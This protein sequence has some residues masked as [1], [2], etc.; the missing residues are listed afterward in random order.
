MNQIIGFAPIAKENAK[1]LILGSMPSD[2][3]LQKQQYYGHQ[4]NAFWPIM[5][6]LL[7]KNIDLDQIDYSQRKKLLIENNIAVWDVLQ[8]CHRSGSL[9]TAIKMNSIQ[10]NPF[11]QFFT[12]HRLISKICFNGA[13]AES[14][15]VKYVLP[16]VRDQFETMKYVRLPSTSPAHAAMTLLQKTQYW[17]KELKSDAAKYN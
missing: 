7:N 4:R 6:S 9:D 10:V 5:L 17:K 15:Y 2:M 13:K 8:S 11:Y 1:I 12:K 16:D 14:I 3:S